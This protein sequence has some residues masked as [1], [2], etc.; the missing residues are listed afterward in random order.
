MQRTLPQ[1]TTDKETR[2]QPRHLGKVPDRGEGVEGGLN[3][4]RS[5]KLAVLGTIDQ[6]KFK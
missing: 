3:E 6:V 5:E 1:I 2:P 4:Q